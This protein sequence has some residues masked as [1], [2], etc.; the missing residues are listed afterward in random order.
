MRG[1][2]CARCRMWVWVVPDAEEQSVVLSKVYAWKRR[3]QKTGEYAWV[4]PQKPGTGVWVL[5]TGACQPARV[6][7]V[8]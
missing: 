4:Q 8:D 7:Q 2:K 1:H 3:R 6:T 5:H